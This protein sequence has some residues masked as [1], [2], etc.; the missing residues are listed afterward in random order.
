MFSAF[1]SRTAARVVGRRGISKIPRRQPSRQMD[2]KGR[3]TLGRHLFNREN[4]ITEYW[5]SRTDGKAKLLAANIALGL[6]VAATYQYNHFSGNLDPDVQINKSRRKDPM[7]H[8]ADDGVNVMKRRE[9]RRSTHSLGH[10]MNR[11]NSKTSFRVPDSTAL[12]LDS[13]AG[14]EG[15]A[16]R[17]GQPKK[18]VRFKSNDVIHQDPMLGRIRDSPF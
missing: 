3:A 9:S 16:A 1:T 5:V 14:E 2:D 15:M 4:S 11:T 10:K 18:L 17:E 7:A 8:T 12:E 13:L 6:G